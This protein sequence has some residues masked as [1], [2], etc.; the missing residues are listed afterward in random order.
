M[1]EIPPDDDAY[2]DEPDHEGV[3]LDHPSLAVPGDED[4]LPHIPATDPA[5]IPPDRG[6]GGLP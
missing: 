4:A 3:S 2:L 1:P 5:T 6:D